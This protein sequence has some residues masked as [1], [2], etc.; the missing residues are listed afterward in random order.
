MARVWTADVN[1]VSKLNI[2]KAMVALPS[3]LHLIVKL[4]NW[5]RLL[6][7]RFM[8]GKRASKEEIAVRLKLLE[9]EGKK[10]CLNCGKRK[11]A[12]DFAIDKRHYDGLQTYCRECC[13][14][15]RRTKYG[16]KVRATARAHFWKHREKRN[17]QKRKYMRENRE[18]FDQKAKEWIAANRE[19]YLARKKRWHE[20]NKEEE[21][22]KARERMKQW[23]SDNPEQHRA[24]CANR[25][26]RLKGAE[27]EYTADQW[28]ELLELCDY[29][30]LAC[31][32]NDED[33]EEDI[34][35]HRDHIVP[36]SE[37]GSNW[38]TNIQPLCQ[39]HNS[40]KHTQTIDYRP[41]HVKQ[42]AEERM[43]ET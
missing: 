35:L 11:S 5:L 1:S 25:E 42:W 12:S 32:V 15:L 37:G 29:K 8:A 39:R 19:K 18:Y 6:Y 3:P 13:N 16:D 26:A 21:N 28:L 22:A 24:N 4:D 36:L 31:V 17:A 40:E 41:D 43:E 14:L 27:G 33:L 9:G 20:A 34:E 10:D 2:V 7:N 38:I 30:C 23:V